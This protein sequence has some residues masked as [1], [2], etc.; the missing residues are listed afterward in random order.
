[1]LTNLKIGKK[2]R[3]VQDCVYYTSKFCEI[4]IPKN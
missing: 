1:M 2:W 4:E 3:L